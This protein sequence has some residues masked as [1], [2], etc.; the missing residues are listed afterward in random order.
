MIGFFIKK[1]FFDGWDNLIGLVLLN[2]GYLG[3]FLLAI[4]STYVFTI[5]IALGFACLL[6]L[7]FLN[8]VYSGAV[9]NCVFGYSAYKRNTWS[10]FKEGWSRYFRHSLLYFFV[11]LVLSVVVALVIPFYMS[12][13]NIVGTILSVVLIW[14]VVIAALCIPYFFALS[15]ALPSDRP[16]KTL[17]KCFIVLADNMGFSI[18][19]LFY[20]IICIALTVFT[21]GLIPGVAGMNL[22]SHDAIRLMML[23]Y[24]YLEENPDADRKHLPWEDIL[25]EER[26]KV[27]PRS[28]KSMIFPWK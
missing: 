10:D 5:N 13:G 17:K 27:G 18:F 9:S 2:L 19:Y 4:L 20:N 3:I 21:L 8:A 6:A 1:A 22:A 26:E 25:Y 24:D 11:T 23:K 7:L 28:F 14:V 12:I 15:S 16:V